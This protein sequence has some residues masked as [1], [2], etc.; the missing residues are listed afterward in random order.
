MNGTI[1]KCHDYGNDKVIVEE[2]QGASKE[3]CNANVDVST[4]DDE[5]P[6]G[7]VITLVTDICEAPHPSTPGNDTVDT[8]EHGLVAPNQSVSLYDGEDLAMFFEHAIHNVSLCLKDE[9]DLLLANISDDEDSIKTSAGDEAGRID[10]DEHH[11]K[12]V[13]KDNAPVIRVKEN[14][15]P[16]KKSLY[17][18]S[19]FSESRVSSM[20]PDALLPEPSV[21]YQALSAKVSLIMSSMTLNN[22]KLS[23]RLAPTVAIKADAPTFGTDYEGHVCASSKLDMTYLERLKKDET[24]KD[25]HMFLCPTVE[26]QT[27]PFKFVAGRKCNRKES[28]EKVAKSSQNTKP[29][30]EFKGS[31]TSEHLSTMINNTETDKIEEHGAT[32]ASDE[33]KDIVLPEF[34]N[35]SKRE[36]KCMID[37]AIQETMKGQTCPIPEIIPYG[38][39]E[40]VKDASSRPIK[41]GEGTYGV[42]VLGKLLLT[43]ETVAIKLPKQNTA[44]VSQVICESLL[45]AKVKNTGTTPE[46]KGLCALESSLHFL[47][48]A[49]ITQF[50]GDP[51]TKATIDYRTF[52]KNE[53]ARLS[54]KEQPMLSRI[55]WLFLLW[56]MA[57]N[58]SAIHREQVVVNDIKSDNIMVKYENGKWTTKFIDLGIAGIQ[59]I[60]SHK[61]PMTNP[62]E[63]A[64]YMIE[65]PH[66][67]PEW[68]IESRVTTQSD[69]YALGRI[70]RVTGHSLSPLRLGI[71]DLAD[72][73]QDAIPQNRPNASN[74]SIS[75]YSKYSIAKFNR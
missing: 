9:D 12:S 48:V 47:Q 73:C 24:G 39:V 58:L 8:S 68:V 10:A 75:L 11:N 3:K 57:E 43:G 34:Q 54:E 67:A 25:G 59:Y 37:E 65:H 1:E 18:K 19:S 52:L 60:D 22:S 71:I 4:G 55:E 15:T 49:M 46:L 53:E 17:E 69:I 72:K 50:I 63:I 23:E 33:T 32:A 41:L 13:S 14:D 20:S 66:I 16:K 45:M 62:F 27:R 5:A 30:P 61:P 64:A 56:K 21:S 42:V 51:A 29:Q 2:D 40:F 7:S 35:I 26:K 38:C 74:V 31:K 36:F 6:Q 44:M 28:K 70:L